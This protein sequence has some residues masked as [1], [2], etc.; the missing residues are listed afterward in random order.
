MLMLIHALDDD[1]NQSR[2]ELPLITQLLID[3]F[4]ATAITL[5]SNWSASEH[6]GMTRRDEESNVRQQ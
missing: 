4:D 5:S 3:T 2:R 6:S 1:E